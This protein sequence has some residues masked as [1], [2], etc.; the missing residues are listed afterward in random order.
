ML[1]THRSRGKLQSGR[2]TRKAIQY[3]P[4]SE[5]AMREMEIERPCFQTQLDEPLRAP[6]R[7][8]T[9]TPNLRCPARD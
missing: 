9:L 3:F 1:E 6:A 4:Q 2:R 5:L 7:I 8:K